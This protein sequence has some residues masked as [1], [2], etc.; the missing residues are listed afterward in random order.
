[1]RAEKERLNERNAATLKGSR[2][3][4]G[5]SE[6]GEEVSESGLKA[7]GGAG[8]KARSRPVQDK[9]EYGVT[10]NDLLIHNSWITKIKYYPDL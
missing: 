4:P 5:G 1:M 6:H 2:R 10:P 9:W 8:N 3:G 7:A